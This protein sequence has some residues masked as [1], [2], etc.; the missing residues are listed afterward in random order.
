MRQ[1]RLRLTLF[2]LFFFGFLSLKGQQLFLTDSST[3]S[4]LTIS[5]GDA[6]YSTFG[7]S[8]IRVKDPTFNLDLNYNYG[9]FNT[10]KED[11]YLKFLKG[12]LPYQITSYPFDLE[13]DYYINKEDRGIEEQVLNLSLEQKQKVFDFLVWNIRPEN[14]EYPYKFFYDNCSTRIRDI[15]QK[16]CGKELVFDT[17]FNGEKSYRDWIHIYS[18]NNEKHW[19]DFGMSLAIGLDSDKKTGYS[20][21]MFIPDNLSKAFDKAQLV[22][23]GISLPL[24]LKKRTIYKSQ[25]PPSS[26]HFTPV[27]FF[28]IIFIIS[29][30]LYFFNFKRIFNVWKGAIFTTLTISGLVI[31]F[32]WFFTDH[33]VTQKNMN[34]LWAF[35]FAVPL[36]YWIKHKQFQYAFVGINIVFLF[37]WAFLPQRIPFAILPLVLSVCVCLVSNIK[38]KD[39]RSQSI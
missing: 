16:I 11:F 17:S 15:L 34:I 9:S 39:E 37:V 29:L 6:L 27:L 14:K 12:Q 31:L 35:P 33:G 36:F 26:N 30:L 5:P 4:L 23:N 20:G 24:V 10:E 21:A 38:N 18:K 8:V 28:G 32:L 19:S 1:T 7:H 25:K 22:Q 3:I 13:T 2:Y